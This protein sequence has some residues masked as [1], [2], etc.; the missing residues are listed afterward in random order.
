PFNYMAIRW[1]RT[2]HPSALTYLETEMHYLL[3]IH[4]G[5]VCVPS[6]ET[7]GHGTRSTRTSFTRAGVGSAMRYALIAYVVFAGLMAGYALS[8]ALRHK[9]IQRRISLLKAQ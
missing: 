9:A 8:L 1:F 4:A 3:W 7:H 2:Q 5:R 6:Q